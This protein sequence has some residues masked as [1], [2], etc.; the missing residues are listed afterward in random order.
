MRLP[1]G[2]AVVESGRGYSPG[3]IATNYRYCKRQECR[4]I[5]LRHLDTE[6]EGISPLVGEGELIISG[7]ELMKSG[8][9]KAGI[10][11]CPSNLE[12]SAAILYGGRH[13]A[14]AAAGAGGLR[15]DR[16]S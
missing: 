4:R 2:G 15:S 7:P 5:A 9:G 16:S 13:A 1:W 14:A 6:V 8:S 11:V 12:R 10:E 3:S